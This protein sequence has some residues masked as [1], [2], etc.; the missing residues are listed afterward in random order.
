LPCTPDKEVLV[1]TGAII[2]GFV[3]L[4]VSVIMILMRRGFRATFLKALREQGAASARGVLEAKVRP[5]AKIGLS[6]ILDQRERMAALALLGDVTAIEQEMAQ[7]TGQLTAVVQVNA[8]GLLGVGV[9]SADPSDA[10]RRLEELATKMESEGGRALVLVKKKTRALAVLARGLTGQQI[11]SP[12]RMTLDSFNGDG[13]M[14]QI[15]VWQATAQ[16]LERVG[17]TQQAQGIR[18]KV[19]QLT[20]AFD[21]PAPAGA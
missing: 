4:A 17:Q 14:V 15:L 6:Q 5:T 20:D 2:G 16:A 3:G 8:L 1:L 11:P 9:R 19:Q 18:G 12:T 21:K 7:H 10:A 13:G